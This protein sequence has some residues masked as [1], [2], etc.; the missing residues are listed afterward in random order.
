MKN[1]FRVSL[2]GYIFD[3]YLA[4]VFLG[5]SLFLGFPAFLTG[6]YFYIKGGIVPF[7]VINAN[8]TIILLVGLYFIFNHF[9]YNR[10]W[11]DNNEKR[12]N[13]EEEK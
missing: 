8:F 4:Q 11:R 13:N 10:N 2:K 6:L 12:S 1:F 5:A 9:I 7:W 3:W